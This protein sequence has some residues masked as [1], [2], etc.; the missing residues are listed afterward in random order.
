MYRQTGSQDS[1]SGNRHR[2]QGNK[3]QGVTHLKSISWRGD[4]T[5]Q[6]GEQGLSRGSSLKHTC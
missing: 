6:V 3:S 5:E 4:V 2:S 1:Q